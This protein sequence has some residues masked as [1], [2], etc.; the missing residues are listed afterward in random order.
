MPIRPVV[1]TGRSEM[2]PPITPS[3]KLGVSS[4]S[5][6]EDGW[7]KESEVED[8]VEYLY[9]AGLF[10]EDHNGEDCVRRL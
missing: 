3:N 10:T 9:C 2:K 1:K 5:E 4:G 6:E 8:D 7:G